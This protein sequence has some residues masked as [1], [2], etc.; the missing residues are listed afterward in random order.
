MLYFSKELINKNKRSTNWKKKEIKIKC[1]M[2]KLLKFFVKTKNKKN[3][4]NN[5]TVKTMNFY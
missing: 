5:V 1:N 3:V 4:F 2:K